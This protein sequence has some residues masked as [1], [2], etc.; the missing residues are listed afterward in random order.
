VNKEQLSDWIA[1]CCKVGTLPIAPGTWGSLAA[2]SVWFWVINYITPIYFILLTV[3][4][5][6]VGVFTSTIIER[7]S[8][9]P[10]PSRI[11]IDEWAGQW[12]ALFFVPQSILYGAAA[13]ILFRIFDI[14]KP[15]FIR[16]LD[17][18]P[19]GWGI[20]IDDAAAGFAALA[21]VQLFIRFV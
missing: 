16:R 3:I 4:I 15:L 20:M 21:C 10:D 14:W 6:T 9:A 17:R 19:G 12:I 1:T 7:V 13:F 5:F 18:Y 11:V 2:V 8:D